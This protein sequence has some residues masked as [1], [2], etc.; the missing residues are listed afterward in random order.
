VEGT[1]ICYPYW[2]DQLQVQ[3]A[4]VPKLERKHGETFCTIQS[5]EKY[6][7]GYGVVERMV[8]HRQPERLI[9]RENNT[10]TWK[11]AMGYIVVIKRGTDTA[12]TVPRSCACV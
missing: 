3:Q 5:R 11:K 1:S 12:I 6:V 4:L 7:A 10:T 2:G 8:A 9:S